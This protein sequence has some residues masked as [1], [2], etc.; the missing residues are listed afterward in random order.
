MKILD[1]MTERCALKQMSPNTARLYRSRVLEF[2]IFHRSNSGEWRHPKEMG[3][4]EVTEFLTHMAVI[5]RVSDST[6]NQ[7][8]SAILFLYREI[9][10]I[11]LKGID[12]VRAKCSQHVPVVLSRSEVNRLLSKMTGVAR[13]SAELMYGSGLRVSEAFAVRVK[14]IDFDRGTI[15]VQQSKGKKSRYTML[16]EPYHD[17]LRS[18]IESVRKWHEDDVKNRL[19]NCL[20]RAYARKNPSAQWAFGWCWLFPS[21]VISEHPETGQWGRFHMQHSVAQK[22][23]KRAVVDAGVHK[24]AGCHT[25]RHTFATHLLESGA[26]LPQI[27]KLL[28]HVKLE[29]TQIYLHCTESPARVLG[30]PLSGLQNVG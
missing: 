28:G 8:L 14:D 9:L 11:D 27:Q 29:T 19:P 6:Q 13:T 3:T 2:L 18:Q 16:P 30:S 12:A 23:I 5:R 22:A 10:R 17:R 4:A 7:A 26:S 15:C 25:L 24:K 1:K 21:R 20:P